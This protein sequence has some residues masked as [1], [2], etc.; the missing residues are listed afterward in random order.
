MA[1][2]NNFRFTKKRHKCNYLVEGTLTLAA[3]STR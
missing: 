1:I 3:A 2:R